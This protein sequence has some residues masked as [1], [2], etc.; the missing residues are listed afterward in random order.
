MPTLNH[1]T[2]LGHLGADPEARFTQ[3]G[4]PIVRLRLATNRRWRNGSDE[5]QEETDWHN[6]VTFGDLAERTRQRVAKGDLVLVDG[7]LQHRTWKADDGTPRS[8]SEVVARTVQALG[9]RLQAGA[10][11]DGAGD[12]DSGP[13][14]GDG[15]GSGDD[16]VPF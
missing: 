12:A 15:S 1:I 13:A 3:S 8:R 9:R 16:D 11:V 14:Q 7:R 4:K 5:W 2:L 6:V 10:S